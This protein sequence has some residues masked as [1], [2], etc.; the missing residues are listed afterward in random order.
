MN[1]A[2]TILEAI[3]LALGSLVVSFLLCLGLDCLFRLVSH[4]DWGLI[5]AMAVGLALA[6]LA[7]NEFLRLTGVLA[8]LLAI[9]FWIEGREWCRRHV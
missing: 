6:L 4:P 9:P 8:I 7:A 5:L 2:V 1:L 3:G